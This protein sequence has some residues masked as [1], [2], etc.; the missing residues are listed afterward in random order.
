MGII[1]IRGM[2]I[3]R[4][5]SAAH[6]YFDVTTSHRLSARGSDVLAMFHKMTKI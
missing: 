4:V 3:D 1:E 5:S 2:H 6:R